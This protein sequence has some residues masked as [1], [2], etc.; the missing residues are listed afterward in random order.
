M[1][2]HQFRFTL[3]LPFPSSILEIP[4]FLFF[5]RIYRND[6]LSP[7]LEILALL[8]QVFKLRVPVGMLFPLLCRNSLVFINPCRLYFSSLCKILLIVGALASNPCCWSSSPILAKLFDVH[9]SGDMGSPRVTASTITSM[10]LTN[11]GSCFAFSFRPPLPGA[12]VGEPTQAFLPLCPLP[13]ADTPPS[14]S[15][16]SFAAPRPQL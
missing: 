10:A 2:A 1:R 8:T 3:R 16:Y 4:N 13:I 11:F 14:P 12:V 15:S 9:F 5:L 7:L 6:G